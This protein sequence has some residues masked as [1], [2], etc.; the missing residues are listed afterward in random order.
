MKYAATTLAL[1]LLLRSNGIAPFGRSSGVPPLALGVAERIMTLT[2]DTEWKAVA[3][4]AVRFVTHHPQGMVKIGESFYVSSVEVKVPP[5]RFSQPTD[6]FDRD[7][8]AG[9]GHLFKIDRAGNLLADLVLGEGTMY[10]PGGIDYDGVNIWVPVAEYRPNSRAVVYRVSV[11]H[12]RLLD[13]GPGF[14]DYRGQRRT[15]DLEEYLE[16]EAPSLVRLGPG[17]GV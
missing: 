12:G 11:D 4:I 7:P 17:L 1:A 15:L 13:R 3:P 14:F 5:K 2:R 8:G 6:G 16:A 10:H 9:T